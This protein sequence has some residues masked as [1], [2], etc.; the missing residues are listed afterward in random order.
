MGS[1]YRKFLL[2]FTQLFFPSGQFSFNNAQWTQRNPERHERH[3]GRGAGLDAARH[4]ERREPEPQPRSR[5]RAA[6][7]S[8][9]T[10][11][12]TG[13]SRR[14]LTRQPRPALRVRRAAHG[15]LQPPELLRSRRAVAAR[16]P[17]AGQRVLRPVA[18]QGRGGV[19]RRRATAARSTPTTTTSARASGF[20]WNCR[21][22][23]GRRGRPTASSTCRRT[24][25]PPA[26]RA[27]PA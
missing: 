24:C 5:P 9:A 16:G 22:E 3:A 2:N 26:T 17:G 21:R 25:R 14:N 15:A 20:A 18:A 1:D 27:P 8:A 7:T 11:R 10:C 23:D 6:R 4:S 12:T 19:R 13:S